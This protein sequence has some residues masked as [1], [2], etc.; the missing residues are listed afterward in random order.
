MLSPLQ[1][2]AVLFAVCAYA[3]IRGR[4]DERTVATICVLATDPDTAADFSNFCDAT[5]HRLL[6]SEQKDDLFVYV[7]EKA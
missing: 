7:I 4:S 2:F 1:Y 6:S 5:G 3:F